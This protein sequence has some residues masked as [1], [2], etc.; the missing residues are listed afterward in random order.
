MTQPGGSRWPAGLALLAEGDLRVYLA[1][2]FCSGAGLTLLRATVAWQVYEISGSPLQLGLLGLVQLVPTVL[3]SLPAGAIADSYDRRR[4]VMLAQLAALA[5]SAL[6]C[7]LTAQGLVTLGAIYAVLFGIA[8][9]SSLENPSGAA[10][11]PSLIDRERFPHAAALSGSIRNLAWVSG[12]VVMGFAVDAAGPAGA[13]ALHAGLLLVSL[14]LIGRIRPRPLEG[15]PR[16]VSLD[17]IREG[18][19]FVRSRPAILAAMTLDML[20][21][22]FGAAEALLP[23]FARDLLGVGPRGYGLLSASFQVGTL[24]MAV[25][26]VALPPLERAGRALLL[27]VVAYGGATIAFGLS[28]SFALSLASY[29]GAGMADQVSM[30]ARSTLI[31]LSTPDALRGRVNSVNFIFIGASNHLGALEAGVVAAATSA[32]FAVLSGGLAAL[33]VTAWMA[34][35]VPALRRYSIR[36]EP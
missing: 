25:A 19:A 1:S 35:R 12:P 27:S 24:T 6:L 4:V 17:A 2:R 18:V 21:V 3:V 31:Q 26:L 14:L 20:A 13:Y 32:T 7:A 28:R 29:A 10:L 16:G 23:V 22:I 8:L 9:A 15:A 11:L 36:D 34:W 33:A 5:G 30:V